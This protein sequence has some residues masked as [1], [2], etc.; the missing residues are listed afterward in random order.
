LTITP[1]AGGSHGGDE[2]ELSWEKEKCAALLE[3]AKTAVVRNRYVFAAVNIGA[4][5]M[6]SAQFNATVP[7]IRNT[8]ERAT[9]DKIKGYLTEFLWRDLGTVSLPLIGIKFSTADLQVIGAVAMAVLAVWMFY[10]TRREN[11]VINAISQE[12]K[13]ALTQ[14]D[15]GKAQY[16]YHGIAHYFVFTTITDNDV[17]GGEHR[18]A[19][20][21]LAVS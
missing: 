1:V 17:P 5:L 9:D 2:I 6:L 4:I 7:W 8:V 14:N 16:L 18:R 20:A 10:A 11:H 13:H 21:R 15:I 19:M 3:A 12:A